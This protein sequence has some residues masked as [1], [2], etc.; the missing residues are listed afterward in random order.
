[1]VVGLLVVMIAGCSASERGT[2]TSDVTV[3][4]ATSSTA[5]AATRTATSAAAST[6]PKPIEIVE[7]GYSVVGGPLVEYAFVFRNPNKD[8]GVQY[9]MAEIDMLD[10]QGSVIATAEAT[11]GRWLLPGESAFYAGEAKPNGK[12]PAKV[13]V[14]PLDPA[15]R[16]KWRSAAEARDVCPGPLKTARVK[17]AKTASGLVFTGEVSNPYAVGVDDFQITVLLRDASGRLLAGYNT[18]MDEIAPG[19]KQT[20]SVSTTRGVPKYATAEVYAQPW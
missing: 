9:P 10:A 2:L 8:F 13:N 20:F 12:I 7:S 17:T 3:T 1:M 5:Q 18:L 11:L 6:T 15:P 14:V 19:E 16:L 4:T